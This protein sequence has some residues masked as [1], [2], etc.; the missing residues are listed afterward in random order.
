[1]QSKSAERGALVS[2]PLSGYWRHHQAVTNE[3]RNCIAAGDWEVPN[4]S[5]TR[6]V[7]IRK[8]EALNC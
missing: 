4:L 6:N 1:M 3:S 7:R 8:V 5:S 2:S